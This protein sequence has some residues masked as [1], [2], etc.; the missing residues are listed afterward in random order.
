MN[1]TR[2]PDDERF[3]G[4]GD[5]EPDW[6]LLPPPTF[7]HPPWT[8]GVVLIMAVVMLILGLL[9]H[10]LWLLIGSPFILTLAVWIWV[11]TVERRRRARRDS[12]GDC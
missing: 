4:E 3:D 12:G 5:G 6:E 7:A 11:K 8:V 1:E 10:P 2:D 9:A